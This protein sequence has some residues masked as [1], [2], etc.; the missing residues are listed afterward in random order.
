MFTPSSLG[1]PGG[2]SRPRAK[3]KFFAVCGYS[4]AATQMWRPAHGKRHGNS[5]MLS[6]TP[7]HLQ[8]RSCK[9]GRPGLILKLGDNSSRWHTRRI[10]DVRTAFESF[11]ANYP[12]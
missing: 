1:T 12:S 6:P 2:L 5:L 4:F 7:K 3:I 11:H 8:L 9:K 10:C